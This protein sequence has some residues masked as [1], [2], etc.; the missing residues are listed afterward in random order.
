MN[1][2]KDITLRENLMRHYLM[3]T[4]LLLLVT[5]ALIME[6]HLGLFISIPVTRVEGIFMGAVV[7]YLLKKLE[8]TILKIRKGLTHL[9]KDG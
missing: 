9:I 3:G 8:V 5:L 7:V 6:Y 4:I 1:L 2:Q